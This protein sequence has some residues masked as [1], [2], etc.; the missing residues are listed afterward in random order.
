[1]KISKQA[2]AAAVLGFVLSGCDRMDT[3]SE[4]KA[5]AAGQ[6]LPTHTQETAAALIRPAPPPTFDN[7]L[8]Q[9]LYE[10]LEQRGRRGSLS[11]EE[12]T[13]AFQ[14]HGGRKVHELIGL[15]CSI[16]GLADADGHVSMHDIGAAFVSDRNQDLRLQGW[17]GVDASIREDLVARAA[18]GTL[19]LPYLQQVFLHI[20]VDFMAEDDVFT[21][22]D[23]VSYAILQAYGVEILVDHSFPP[24]EIAVFLALQTQMEA[25]RHSDGE[26]PGTRN[27]TQEILFP[28]AAGAGRADFF[29][30]LRGQD[31]EKFL[32][33]P[34]KDDGPTEPWTL[35]HAADAETARAILDSIAMT[36]EAKFEAALKGPPHVLE[37]LLKEPEFDHETIDRLIESRIGVVNE[38][39]E[40]EDKAEMAV[41]LRHMKHGQPWLDRTFIQSIKANKPGY[42]AAFLDTTPP[43]A[44]ALG[45]AQAIMR[46]PPRNH[47]NSVVGK[48]DHESLLRVLAQRDPFAPL[49]IPSP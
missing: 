12:I 4:V 32:M 48:Q 46:H 27:A 20:P 47:T 8:R 6:A 40:E 43:S 36:P 15:Y 11:I 3:A 38:I 19:T 41:I 1:M 42:A 28:A 45:K 2:F 34:H 7:S 25:L 21:Q 9:A 33:S 23:S 37:E 14:S 10:D 31:M 13:D 17:T 39:R 16:K 49:P 30:G 22:R 18:N 26:R 24:L 29:Y 44:A 35:T 5:P